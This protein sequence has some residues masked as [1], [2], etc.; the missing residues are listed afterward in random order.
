VYYIAP[1]V[2]AWASWRVKKIIRLTDHVAC[3]L[4]FEEAWLRKRGVAATYVGHPLFDELPPRPESLPDLTEAWSSGRWKVALLAGSREGE[5]HR[6]ARALA[7]TAL[8]IRARWPEAVCTFTPGTQTNADL[9]RRQLS[10]RQLQQVELV[11]GQTPQVLAESHFAVAVSGT[12]TLEVAWYGVPMVIFYRVNRWAY[13]LIGRWLLK[14]KYLSLANIIANREVVPELMPWYGRSR[15]LSGTVLEMMDDLGYLCETRNALLDTV[16]PL[17]IATPG[18]ASKNA[19]ELVRSVL[20]N[21][22]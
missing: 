18:S 4:P 7:D 20:E 12:V 16:N 1:Q 6:H 2:W 22:S 11:V 17:R 8:A 10:D 3:I 5:I 14:T 9:I 15:L 21:R 19:A 13:N